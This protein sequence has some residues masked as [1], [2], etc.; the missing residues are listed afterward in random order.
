MSVRGKTLKELA[1]AL[2]V[3]ITT[4]SR[5]LAGHD[6]IA[7]KTR[8]R[9]MEA[10]RSYGYVPNVAARQLVSGRS[11]FIGLVLPIRGPNLVDFFLGEFITGLGEGVVSK[12]SHLIL[13][14]APEGEPE[15]SVLRHLVES[16]RCDG[17]VVT[18]I[19]ETDDRV[20]YLRDRNVPFVAHGRLLDDTTSYNWLDTDGAY[21]FGEAFD[22]LYALG[23]RRFGLVTISELMTFRHRRQDGLADA[24]ARRGD[25]AVTLEVATASRFDRGARVEA[26]NRL[27]R[28]P[29]RPTAIIGLFDDLALTVMEEA[30]RAGLSIPRDL[31]VIGFDNVLASAYAPPGLTTFDAEIQKAAREIGEMLITVIEE[32]P[33]EPIQRLIKPTLV[34]RASHGRAPRANKQ[35]RG[36]KG[37]RRS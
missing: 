29:N 2:N 26:I 23:H 31:S 8:Q 15:L 16:G 30:A 32:R 18:R 6:A 5:A 25:P 22:M 11:G 17:V 19:A 1:S 7:L 14:T 36:T 33:K 21:A 4:V 24:I 3:S 12:G 34:A 13:A 28:G 37:G 10:A 20:A 27:L 35:P 9:V